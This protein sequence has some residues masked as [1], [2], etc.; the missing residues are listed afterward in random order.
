MINF[1]LKCHRFRRLLKFL[2]YDTVNRYSLSTKT[3]SWRQNHA[4]GSTLIHGVVPLKLPKFCCVNPEIFCSQL[5]CSL[6]RHGRLLLFS[7]SNS[8]S[9]SSCKGLKQTGSYTFGCSTLRYY[10]PHLSTLYHSSAEG[11]HLWSTTGRSAN[12]S[13]YGDLL[14]LLVTV[15][16]CRYHPHRPFVQAAEELKDHLL[17]GVL[18]RRSNTDTDMLD[19][20]WCKT[21]V[22]MTVNTFRQYS[23]SPWKPYSSSA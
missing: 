3:K 8:R 12:T 9:M 18:H 4:F 7:L 13:P 6:Y 16:H 11:Y 20:Q 17:S 23:T 1:F 22:C 21:G 5:L 2:L 14:S 19:K 15:H 10:C